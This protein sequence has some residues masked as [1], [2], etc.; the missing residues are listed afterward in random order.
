VTA[1]TELGHGHSI[2]LAVWDPDLELN[3]QYAHLAGQL[4]ATVSGIVRHLKPDGSVCEGVVTFDT[5]IAREQFSGPFWQV[6]SWDPLTL[7]P[8]L[9]CHCGDHGHIQQGRWVPA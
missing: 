1:R 2:S 3:P 9:K 4:P 6:E 5:P 8:S 7:S